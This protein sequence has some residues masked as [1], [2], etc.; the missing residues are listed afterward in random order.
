VGATISGNVIHDNAGAGLD[1]AS[2]ILVPVFIPGVLEIGLGFVSNEISHNAMA[3]AGCDAAQSRAQIHVSAPTAIPP[4]PCPSAASSLAC[5]ALNRPVNQHCLW[6]GSNCLRA[7]DLKGDVVPKCP[8]GLRN[9]I[10]DYDTSD[11]GNVDS[12]G[13]RAVGNAH[14]DLDHNEWQDEASSQNVTQGTG[15][16]VQ[17]SSTCGIRGCSL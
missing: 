15:S 8:T 3:G 11:S 10:F 12:V 13:A 9:A 5:G 1:L 17:A 2:A 14:V 6:T 7:H 16:F 4:G